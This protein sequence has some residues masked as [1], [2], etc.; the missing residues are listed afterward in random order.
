MF[1]HAQTLSCSFDPT[2]SAHTNKMFSSS[3]TSPPHMIPAG[4]RILE[5]TDSS[6]SLDATLNLSWLLAMPSTPLF[7]G[8]SHALPPV[9]AVPSGRPAVSP[10]PHPYVTFRAKPSHQLSP[11]DPE[12]IDSQSFHPVWYSMGGCQ[13]LAPSRPYPQVSTCQCV[14][15]PTTSIYPEGPIFTTL[16]SRVLQSWGGVLS[17]GVWSLRLSLARWRLP[18]PI[19]WKHLCQRQPHH[20]VPRAYQSSWKLPPS[21]ASPLI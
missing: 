19:H 3:A 14:G 12:G 7:P 20:H 13:A 17:V 2:F 16:S 10:M 5:A 9:R 21:R 6:L 18:L 8:T 15:A 4:R 1:S 11:P